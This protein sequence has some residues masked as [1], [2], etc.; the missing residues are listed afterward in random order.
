MLTLAGQFRH[1]FCIGTGG[2]AVF[3]SFGR[4]AVTS[5]AR[6]FRCCT[7]KI[8]FF[9][10]R[11]LP[12]EKRLCAQCLPI[13]LSRRPYSDGIYSAF[14]LSNSIAT[15]QARIWFVLLILLLRVQPPNLMIL[16]NRP[17]MLIGLFESVPLRTDQMSIRSVDLTANK[18]LSRTAFPAARVPA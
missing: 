12:L 18:A 2:A 17:F 1:A 4:D 8:S 5:R 14:A 10:E 9:V 16:L 15:T 6:A 3:L 7:H 13:T 11:A